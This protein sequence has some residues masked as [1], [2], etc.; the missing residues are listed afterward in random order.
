MS[1]VLNLNVVEARDIDKMDS[2][3][4]TDP[5]CEITFPGSKMVKTSVKKN[6]LTPNWNETFR[7]PVFNMKSQLEILMKDEDV[8]KDDKMA[9][10]ELHLNALKIGDV[11]DCW[12]PMTP[13]K[14]K[15]G[16]E[17]H[18]IIHLA[19]KDDPPFAKKL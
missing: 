16:G 19:E 18:L 13:I 17:I 9:N 7:F 3:G 10:L 8:M 14:A 11:V 4:K 1:Y 5:Y 2:I 12:L 6:T 15:K